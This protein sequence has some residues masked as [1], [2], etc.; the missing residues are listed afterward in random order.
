MEQ[1]ARTTEATS[2]LTAT[3]EMSSPG[4]TS[5]KLV[6]TLTMTTGIDGCLAN[7]CH[8]QATCTDNPA[9]ALDATC[10]CNPGFTGDGLVIGT[11]CSDLD[12]CLDNPC[13]VQA[14]CTDNSPPYL[15]ATCTCNPGYTGDGLIEGTGCSDIDSCST[16]PCHVRA[17]CTDKPP[18][19]LNA[20]CTCN[21]GYTGD[22]LV[23]G[24]GCSDIDG[25]L[26][27]PCHR[28][29]TCTDNPPP[30]LNA[31]C[32]CN[33][34]YTGDGLVRGTGCSDSDACSG[35]PCHRHATCTDKPPPALNATCT[36]NTGYTGDGLGRGTGCSDINDCDPNPC[37]NGGS[38]T[39]GVNRYTCAC[40]PEYGGD[41]CETEL[42]SC[43]S[44]KC[45]HRAYCDEDLD[46]C[47]C[48]H[49]YRGNGITCSEVV[50]YHFACRFPVIIFT[51]QLLAITSASFR[52]VERVVLPPFQIVIQSLLV[53]HDHDN[54]GRPDNYDDGVENMR[55]LRFRPGSLIAVYE[56]NLTV[57][58]IP[59]L[60]MRIL[61]ATVD[62]RIGNLTVQGKYTVFGAKAL[63]RCHCEDVERCVER[64]STW[65]CECRAG[66]N[67]THGAE[68]E[69]VDECTLGVNSCSEDSVC[70]NTR[71]S[72]RCSF[73]R[74]IVNIRGGG[75]TIQRTDRLQL[76]SVI[77]YSQKC[78]LDSIK[79][80]SYNWTFDSPDVRTRSRLNS[81]PRN[82][83]D[84]VVS[85]NTMGIGRVAFYL[86]VEAVDDHGVALSSQ[87][88]TSITVTF[89]P[90]MAGI[91]GGSRRQTGAGSLTLD[92][93]TLSSDPN[94]LLSSCDLT[95]DWSCSTLTDR[96]ECPRLQGNPSCGKATFV[97]P[98]S[99]FTR[100]FNFTVAVSGSGRIPGR[101]TQIIE[102]VKAEKLSIPRPQIICEKLHGTCGPVI[103]EGEQMK[104]VSVCENC[105]D[106]SG[107][108]SYT[109]WW[110]LVASPAGYTEW[111]DR[112]YDNSLLNERDQDY[113][114]MKANIFT[115]PGDYTIRVNITEI[116][117]NL[118][119]YAEYTFTTN[120]PPSVG[121]CT[122]TPPSG[123][124]S[125]D[126]FMICC[127]GFQDPDKPLTY[128]FL[129][130]TDIDIAS[131]NT[132]STSAF[133]LLYTGPENCTALLK[134]PLGLKEKKYSLP[135]LV[136]VVDRY[137][138]SVSV[139]PS[140]PTVRPPVISA[141]RDFAEEVT[142]TKDVQKT[143]A[144]IA[145]V[146]SVLNAEENT[147]DTETQERIQE[148]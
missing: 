23:R 145:S 68:C 61:N 73:C 21:P 50:T 24:T 52:Q 22:G 139:K 112:D 99:F 62:D 80:I 51:V 69:D 60:E 70:V 135:L 74:P 67:R 63:A 83:A 127:I 47:V 97:I 75:R 36:C 38:C 7:P 15:N 33:P 103:K 17:T 104:L 32:T 101:A 90:L 92:A 126:D 16:D 82:Q 66:Y 41:N 11:G 105:E 111:T 136:N 30:A 108:F 109:Y 118:T 133:H 58:T 122:V 3:E 125:V 115:Q 12:A 96:G 71:G 65:T 123:T 35:N 124:A 91:L 102:V 146:S 6:T 143:T 59:D 113:L 25:C 2:T 42:E 86:T 87:T 79:K 119:G 116:P 13:H 88:S 20:T 40:E 128:N 148:R 56:L 117:T 120:G 78:L 31:T 110:A 107:D 4:V 98:E 39:D 55:V 141:V 64:D 77:N 140:P 26:A 81:L 138:G 114:V 89:S 85:P 134:L 93:A 29:A 57:D 147:T 1:S 84:V 10:T 34:G 48:Q 18:P 28:H 8:V 54:D 94:G 43:G 37:Q 106:Q 132:T 76:N 72:Y 121:L 142:T 53:T 46:R 49:G 45:H 44:L 14:N 19:A 131:V 95:Y 5:T 144:V 129:Y 137:G 27:N 130:E 100:A 9:P